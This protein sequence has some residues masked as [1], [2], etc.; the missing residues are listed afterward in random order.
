[1]VVL[2]V[3]EIEERYFSFLLPV[4]FWFI[5]QFLIESNGN[6][7]AVSSNE[8]DGAAFSEYSASTPISLAV[9][10]YYAPLF[11]YNLLKI[12]MV[13]KSFSY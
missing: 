2:W 8:V 12:I 7:N 11:K 13:S 10:K 3:E 9:A 6:W 4:R 5:I 1:L